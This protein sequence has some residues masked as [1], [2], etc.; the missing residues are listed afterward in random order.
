MVDAVTRF[1]A[2]V[3]GARKRRVGPTR[4]GD[5]LA[6]IVF[7]GHHGDPRAIKVRNKLGGAGL[8][9]RTLFVGVAEGLRGKR[10]RNLPLFQSLQ[11][12]FGPDE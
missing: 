10:L 5:P 1:L 6:T 7:G 2:F 12:V 11:R 8:F 9:A 3:F 4:N